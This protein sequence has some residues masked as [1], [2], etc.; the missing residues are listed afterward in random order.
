MEF[1]RFEA[2]N[3]TIWLPAQS[4]VNRISWQRAL[5]VKDRP[6]KFGNLE[7]SAYIYRNGVV[8][9]ILSFG[10]MMHSHVSRS[11]SSRLINR[12]LLCE[13]HSR[14]PIV[15]VPAAGTGIA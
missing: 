5:W 4:T 12:P 7:V 2:T 13:S 14:C 10:I 6:Q 1:Q 9:R 11:I 15:V 8:Q 3:P